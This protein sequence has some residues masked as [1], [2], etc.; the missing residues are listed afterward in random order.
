MIPQ[1]NKESCKAFEAWSNTMIRMLYLPWTFYLRQCEMGYRRLASNMDFLQIRERGNPVPSTTTQKDKESLEKLAR[2]RV[3]EGLAPPPEI[4]LSP[5]REQ[6]DW[7]QFPLWARPSDPELFE[8]S[9]HE[10]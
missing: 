4:Y 8:G 6:I 7:L 9:A 10:G 3:K 1:M 2:E 5:T